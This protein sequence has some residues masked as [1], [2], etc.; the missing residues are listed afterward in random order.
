MG[1][2]ITARTVSLND[3]R[4]GERGGGGRRVGGTGRVMYSVCSLDFCVLLNLDVM[5]RRCTSTRRQNYS[6]CQFLQKPGKATF[7]YRLSPSTCDKNI[8]NTTFVFRLNFPDFSGTLFTV[9]PVPERRSRGF[10]AALLNL[11]PSDIDRE[12]LCKHNMFITSITTVQSETFSAF[13][14]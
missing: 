3:S 9:V 10:F 13:V 11:G 14:L 6:C 7:S 12:R 1:L 5:V 4:A 2:P 8:S